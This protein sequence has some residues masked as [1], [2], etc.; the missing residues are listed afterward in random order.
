MKLNVTQNYATRASS[1]IHL[2]QRSHH[3]KTNQVAVFYMI[4]T[5][6]LNEF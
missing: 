5:L 1:L 2:S 3:I 4:V 6:M